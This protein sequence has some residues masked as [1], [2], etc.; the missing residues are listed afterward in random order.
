M[1]GGQKRVRFRACR[2]AGIVEMKK[3]AGFLCK[4]F[5]STFM[6]SAFT[7]GGGYVIIPMMR[8]RFV[9]QYHWIDEEELLDMPKGA[10]MVSLCRKLHLIR[11]QYR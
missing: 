5:A 4:L 6:L 2:K 1:Q 7:F 3:N 9:E 10:S 8:R 11:G